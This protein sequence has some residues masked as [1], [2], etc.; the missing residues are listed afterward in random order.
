MKFVNPHTHPINLVDGR[1]VQALGEFDLSK[2]QYE[3]GEQWTLL[4]DY[5][6]ASPAAEKLVAE[7]RE[8]PGKFNNNTEQAAPALGESGGTA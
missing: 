1:E 8:D 2:E 5:I 3:N 6:G 7:A 4:P